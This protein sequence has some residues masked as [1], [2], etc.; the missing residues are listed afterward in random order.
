MPR[1]SAEIVC[2]TSSNTAQRRSINMVESMKRMKKPYTDQRVCVPKY[3]VF[4]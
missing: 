2:V 1:N 3:Y 4:K